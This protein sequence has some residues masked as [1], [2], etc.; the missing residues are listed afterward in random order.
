MKE[1][2]TYTLAAIAFYAVL[3]LIMA[4]PN[5]VFWFKTLYL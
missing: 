3:F 1:L 5:A 2:I 4:G